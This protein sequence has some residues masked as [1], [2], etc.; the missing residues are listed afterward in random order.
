MPNKQFSI[1][2][3][4]LLRFELNKNK[5]PEKTRAK[6]VTLENKLKEEEKNFDCIFERDYL[7]YK[8]KL[9]QIYAERAGSLK[10]RSKSEW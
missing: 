8:N 7:D 10:I 5:I 2:K 1:T 6:T 3:S 9:E 4:K